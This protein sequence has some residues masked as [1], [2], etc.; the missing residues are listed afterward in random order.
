MAR[1]RC[2]GRWLW[3]AAGVAVLGGLSWAQAPKS[4][5]SRTL[6][7]AEADTAETPAKSDAKKATKKKQDELPPI[8]PADPA[9]D[10]ILATNPTTPSELIRAGKALADLRRADL[11][12]QYFRRVLAANLDAQSLAA[13]ADEF[14]SA[15]FAAMALRHDLDPEGKQ[16]ADAVLG[17]KSRQLQDPKRLEGLIQQLADPSPKARALAIAGLQDAGIAAVGPL[18]AVLGDSQRAAEHA[19]ARTALAALGSIALGPLTAALDASDPRLVVEAIHLLGR[20]QAVRPGYFLLRPCFDEKTTPEVRTAARAAAQRLWRRVPEREE[21]AEFLAGLALRYAE[22]KERFESDASGQVLVWSWDGAKRQAVSRAYKEEEAAR[23]FAARLA[24]DAYVI[25]PDRRELL[26]L[27]LTTM[28]EQAAHEAGLD[29]AMASGPDSPLGKLAAMDEEAVEQ[30]LV[31]A[32]QHGQSAAATA[33]AH[34]LGAMPGVER[35]LT[36]AAQPCP[37]VMATRHED[38]R[39]RFAAVEAVMRCQPRGPF[40]G[41]SYVSEAIRFMAASRGAK[42]VLV[43]SPRREESMRL[44]GLLVQLGYE[45]EIAATGRETLQKALD[46]PD[47]EIVLLDAILH[48]PTVDEVLQ[49]LRRDGRTAL[50]PVGVLA[51]AGDLER[52]R[53]MARDDPRAEAFSRPHDFP[54]LQW[55]IERL[56]ALGGDLLT[57]S[58]RKRQASAALD[59]LAQG[60]PSSGGWMDAW[61]VEST[62]VRALDTP[63]L[64]PKACVVLGNLGT[65]RAQQALVDLASR[66]TVPLDDRRAALDAFRFAVERRGILLTTT[67]IQL[68][69]DRYNQSAGEDRA[70]QAILSQILDCL[71]APTSPLKQSGAGVEMTSPPTAHGSELPE[72]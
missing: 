34:I 56:V 9:V 13:L 48:Y 28:L 12:K 45:T 69:Y 30:V 17:A 26:W 21:A 53:H 33:A 14:D 57:P 38:R 31:F 42:R 52:A 49:A 22:R 58:A 2:L 20:A 7:A 3:V 46:S 11:A 65:P 29:A 35:L 41:A 37:L 70:T 24:R 4:G 50:L 71:E 67:K 40:P 62:V 64:T 39:L 72:S 27:H 47:Y 18:L 36:R 16:L 1:F 51:A 25:L 10:V 68:Q 44:A 23:W 8:A 60:I 54:A 15:T 43:G 59:W 55:Q 19:G 61:R 5:P 63:G 66:K 32:M 6:S